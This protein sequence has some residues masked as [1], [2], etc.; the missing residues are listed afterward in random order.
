[1]KIVDES[2][3]RKYG[4]VPCGRSSYNTASRFLKRLSN[5]YKIINIDLKQ[6]NK[7]KRMHEWKFYRLIGFESYDVLLKEIFRKP[8]SE[9]KKQE[10]IQKIRNEEIFD[11]D[12]YQGEEY[13]SEDITKENIV[14]V[15]LKKYAYMAVIRFE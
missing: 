13:L 3:L 2:V 7:E 14:D 6:W 10:F 4:L 11:W 8:L 1:M 12:E 9:E 15:M 5:D